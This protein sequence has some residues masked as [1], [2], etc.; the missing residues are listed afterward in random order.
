MSGFMIVDKG[1][2]WSASGGV[3]DWTL[4]FLGSKVSDAETVE[5][6]ADVKDNVQMLALPDFPPPVRN[7][8]VAIIRNDLV[9]A[10]ER[11]LPEG[12]AKPFALAALQELVDLTY[13]PA[14]PA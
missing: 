5:Y 14:K 11:D 6:L 13:A 3:F 1:V 9:A 2:N 4:E 10:A 7:E 8:L 12:E